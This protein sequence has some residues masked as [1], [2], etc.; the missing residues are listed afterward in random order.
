M[1]TGERPVALV[2]TFSETARDRIAAGIAAGPAAADWYV[3]HYGVNRAHAEQITS[4]AGCRYAPV[5]GVQPKTSHQTRLKRRLPSADAAAVGDSAHAGE[6]PGSSTGS[7][8]PPRDQRGWGLELGRRFRDALRAWRARGVTIDTWQFDEVL[9]EC[10]NSR[11]HRAFVGGVLRGL[12]EGRPELGDKPEQGFVWVAFTA[13][14]ALP[15]MQITN[16]LQAFWEDLDAATLFLVGEEY[17]PFT[18]SPAAHASERSVGH[19]ALLNAG[20]LRQRLGKRYVVGM[21]P[22]FLPARAGLGGRT[23]GMSPAAARQFRDSFITARAAIGQ[24]CGFGQFNF[25]R[26]NAQQAAV[27]DAIQSLHHAARLLAQ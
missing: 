11:P 18:G 19:R 16:E 5:F 22:G 12:A 15:G 8:I 13:F 17:P 23:P 7:V 10:R 2:T 21:S 14:R 1:A 26:E 3:G 9:G 25:V 24:P 6:V 20:P 27:R 4:I